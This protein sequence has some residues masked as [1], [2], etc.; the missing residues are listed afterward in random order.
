MRAA[1]CE[2]FCSQCH[3][4]QMLTATNVSAASRGPVPCGAPAASQAVHHELPHQ[5]TWPWLSWPGWQ[6]LAD[7]IRSSCRCT[8][9]GGDE[10]HSIDQ[11]DYAQLGRL[12]RTIMQRPGN[13]HHGHVHD[14]FFRF[15]RYAWLPIIETV[16]LTNFTN[17]RVAVARYTRPD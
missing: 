6:L 14:D 9:N 11:S 10:Q 2:L 16:T 17:A 12:S 3:M 8:G 4:L 15:K 1:G 5:P 13:P 7:S